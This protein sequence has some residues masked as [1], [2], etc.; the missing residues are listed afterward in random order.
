MA[1]PLG[2]SRSV[3]RRG[4]EGA[5]ALRIEVGIEGRH[6]L[7]TDAA[8]GDIAQAR[9]AMDGVHVAAAP[10]HPGRLQLFDPLAVLGPRMT[11]GVRMISNSRFRPSISES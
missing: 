9:H 5:N 4:T 2:C 1:S 10:V 7:S 11:Y 8:V 3:R 6:L